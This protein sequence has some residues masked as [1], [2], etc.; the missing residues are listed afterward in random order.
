MLRKFESYDSLTVTIEVGI[1]YRVYN[2][3]PVD[4]LWILKYIALK[5]TTNSHAQKPN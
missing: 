2:N 4:T 3:S 1:Y 5:Y